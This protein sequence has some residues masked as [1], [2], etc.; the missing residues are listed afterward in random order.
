MN[1]NTK[2]QKNTT[3][4]LFEFYDITTHILHFVLL[5][6]PRIIKSKIA[7]SESKIATANL[8]LCAPFASHGAPLKHSENSLGVYS[9]LLAHLDSCMKQSKL[10]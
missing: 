7:I 10:L 2:I 6:Y 8:N 4:H 5:R 1:L 3:Y 9:D